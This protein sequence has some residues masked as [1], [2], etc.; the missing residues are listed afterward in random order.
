MIFGVRIL[1]GFI[2]GNPIAND[3]DFDEGSK[4]EF[5][6]GM[7]L[8]SDEQ[9]QVNQINFLYS[10]F[11]SFPLSHLPLIAEGSSFLRVLRV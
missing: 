10:F 5:S 11:Q 2:V 6:H 7:G 1:Q 4:V 9:Y 8:I 3:L